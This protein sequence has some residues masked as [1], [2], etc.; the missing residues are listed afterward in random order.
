[1][2]RYKEIIK[3]AKII[4]ESKKAKIISECINNMVSEWHK[5]KEGDKKEVA[6]VIAGSHKFSE[7]LLL[8]NGIEKRNTLSGDLAVNK[9][10]CPFPD[11]CD[12]RFKCTKNSCSYD[13]CSNGFA[14]R[15]S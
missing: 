2:S 9:G 6:R 4:H 3:Y 15:M 5:L 10:I 14:Y 13:T 8:M 11:Q 1:M 12:E 7:F